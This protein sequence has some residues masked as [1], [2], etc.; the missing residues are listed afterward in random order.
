[1]SFHS[2]KSNTQRHPTWLSKG[3]ASC[4]NR[5]SSP[6]TAGPQL[7]NTNNNSHIIIIVVITII[8]Y[9]AVP[10]LLLGNPAGA[11]FGRICK[12]NLAGASAGAGF[13]HIISHQ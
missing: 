5:S 2:A 4:R 10:D 1:L 9:R 13:H 8:I 6:Q 11:R 7:I 12:A 3:S